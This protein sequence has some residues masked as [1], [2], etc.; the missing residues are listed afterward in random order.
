MTSVASYQNRKLFSRIREFI[1]N[2]PPVTQFNNN[3]NKIEIDNKVFYWIGPDK[4]HMYY[5]GEFTKISNYLECTLLI[6]EYDNTTYTEFDLL[7]SILRT[8]ETISGKIYDIRQ[9]SENRLIMPALDLCD[10]LLSSCSI[11]VN[12]K[13]IY[14]STQLIPYIKSTHTFH[15]K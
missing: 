8:G 3:L 11:T 12:N 2:G 7:T 4:T 6:S 10:Q 1:N 15:I 5:A 13:E 9:L 14:S